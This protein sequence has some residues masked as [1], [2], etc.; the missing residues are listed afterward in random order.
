M[1]HP[2]A[3]GAAQYA[4]NL[5]KNDLS[6]NL[7]YHSKWHTECEIVPATEELAQM[8]GV[9]AEA[10]M[11]LITAAWY[12]DTGFT[13]TRFNHEMAS[14]QIAAN[15]LP[16]YGYSPE[17]VDRIK[18]LIMATVFPQSPQTHHQMII[19]DADMKNL[20]T[21]IFFERSDDLRQELAAFGTVYTDLEWY[22]RQVAFITAQR[23]FTQSARTL[24]SAKL[25]E[26]LGCLKMIHAQL[27]EAASDK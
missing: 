3:S 10:T 8:E 5:L 11:L 4:L 6:G 13:L 1:R 7:F 24:Y 9:D 19:A 20:G 17:Q 12:H 27:K 2:D 26:N 21:D 15:V 23:Y 14:S 16:S 25:Q 18:E 22:T